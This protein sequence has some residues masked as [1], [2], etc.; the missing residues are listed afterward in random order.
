MGPTEQDDGGSGSGMALLPGLTV[1][2]P[3]ASSYPSIFTY[4]ARA[5]D[6]LSFSLH[7]LDTEYLN[8]ALR[9]VRSA[10]ELDA[11]ETTDSRGRVVISLDAVVDLELELI[12]HAK[13]SGLFSV[14]LEGSG[15]RGIDEDANHA[16]P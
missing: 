4:A 11:E 10:V 2:I 9:D 3:A 1:F 12:V 16:V 15:W 14:T 13:D 8:S 7:A 5:G 6:R